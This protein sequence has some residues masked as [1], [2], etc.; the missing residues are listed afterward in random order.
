VVYA[1]WEVPNVEREGTDNEV[2]TAGV[3]LKRAN[4]FS[5]HIISHGLPINLIPGEAL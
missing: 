4:L 2:E 1:F 5:L 3:E